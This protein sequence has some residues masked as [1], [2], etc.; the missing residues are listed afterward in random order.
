M[1]LLG[2]QLLSSLRFMV[3]FY[4]SEVKTVSD[5]HERVIEKKGEVITE[6]HTIEAIKLGAMTSTEITIKEQICAM[7]VS[8]LHWQKEDFFLW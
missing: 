5:M 6:M 1:S 2:K 3:D 7:E 8:V 4:Q